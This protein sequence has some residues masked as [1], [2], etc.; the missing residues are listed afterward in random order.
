MSRN[1]DAAAFETHVGV[2]G[3]IALF[4]YVDGI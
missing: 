2:A 3:L 4:G 1:H